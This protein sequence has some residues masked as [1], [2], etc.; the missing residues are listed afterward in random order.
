[1]SKQQL[2][3]LSEAESWARLSETARVNEENNGGPAGQVTAL[4]ENQET[5]TSLASGYVFDNPGWQTER[6]LQLLSKIFDEWTIHYIEQRGIREGW[7]CLEVGGGGGSIAAWLCGR[8][9]DTGRVLATDIDTRFLDALTFPNL[10]VRRHDL[11]TD[12]LPEQEFDLVHTR[13]VLVHLPERETILKRLV[14][15]VRPGGWI[16]IEEVEDFLVQTKSAT[17]SQEEGLK[18]RNAFVQFLISR[19]VDINYAGTL[20]HT[21]SANGLANVGAD[22]FTSIWKSGSDGVELVK[23]NCREL[24]DALIGSAFISEAEFESAMKR[25]DEDD[26]AIQAPLMWTAWGQLVHS[27]SA[28][29]DTASSAQVLTPRS[30][31]EAAAC[32]RPGGSLIAEL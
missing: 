6:R 3:E 28:R 16:V 26:F 32:A 10:E 19:G 25:A 17:N 5:R 23:L 14:S 9:G 2:N 29:V 18:L 24:R 13:C 12:P 8:V 30:K 21:L 22:A 4:S 11:R 20:A 31:V 7:S 1:M 15:A 27:P